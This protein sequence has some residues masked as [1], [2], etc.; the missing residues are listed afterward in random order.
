MK[1]SWNLALVA[2]LAVAGC[3]SDKIHER[4]RVAPSPISDFLP[5]HQLLERQADTFPFHYY[6][7]KETTKKYEYAY[8]APVN[9]QYLRESKGWEQFDRELS[10]KLGDDVD[11]LA[12]FMQKAYEQAFRKAKF[13]DHLKLTDRK[14]Q[15]GTLI[16]ESAIIGISPTKAELKAAGTAASFFV[17]GIGLVTSLTSPGSLTVECRVRDAETGEVIAMYAD[18]EKDPSALF[19]PASYTWTYSARINIKMIAAQTAVV[20]TTH[21]RWLLRRDFPIRLTALIKDAK[22]DE[23]E[24]A[25][26]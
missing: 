2:A 4:M 16:I 7:A 1:S 14:D 25:K 26:K 24:P 23:E 5:N 15:P 11:K 17:P 10:G 20:L 21:D 12:S 3:Q 13:P 18:T 8:V 9:T 6:Y 19:A 22:L